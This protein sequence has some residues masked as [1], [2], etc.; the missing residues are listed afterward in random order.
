MKHFSKKQKLSTCVIAIGFCFFHTNVLAQ[1]A[2]WNLSGQNIVFTTKDLVGINTSQPSKAL[3]VKS[4]HVI[5]VPPSPPIPL[6]HNGMRLGHYILEVVGRAP[7]QGNPPPADTLF[8][9]QWDLEPVI[10]TINVISKFQ[11]GPPGNPVITLTEDGRVF[12]G[13]STITSG[14]HA[15]W[16]FSTDGKIVA[17]KI[18]ATKVNWADHMLK[19]GFKKMPFEEFV[20]FFRENGYFYNMP[21][22]EQLESEGMDVVEIIT[23]QQELIELL[24]LYMAD[25]REAK[26]TERQ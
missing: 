3:D 17:K 12:I 9:S 4:V 5:T 20:K 8:S 21:S 23:K 1:G 22:Q 16:D 14:P 2:P 10:D 7:G 25:M 19:K 11:M 15:D 18:I 24:F 6:S 13:D 26:D